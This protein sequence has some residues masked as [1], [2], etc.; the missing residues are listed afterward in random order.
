MLNTVQS[1][2]Q[3]QF[4]SHKPA[5]KALVSDQ[6]V[7]HSKVTHTSVTAGRLGL[8]WPVWTLLWFLS[9]AALAKALGQ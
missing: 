3:K 1:H 7:I 5:I 2:Q 6:T 4:L 8:L 9:L